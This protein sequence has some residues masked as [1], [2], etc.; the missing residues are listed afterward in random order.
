MSSNEGVLSESLKSDALTNAGSLGIGGW[1]DVP[2]P[3]VRH[4]GRL[5]V[6]ARVS[7]RRADRPRMKLVLSSLGQQ[8][9]EEMHPDV[10]D[11]VLQMGSCLGQKFC[12]SGWCNI[13]V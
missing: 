1:L 9:A 4:E 2:A 13:C 7:D 8:W 5:S 3:S 11:V 6:S 10:G 12:I